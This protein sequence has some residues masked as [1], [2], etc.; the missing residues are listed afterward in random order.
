MSLPFAQRRYR[1]LHFLLDPP[2][3]ER[4]DGSKDEKG[5]GVGAADADFE[6][7]CFG[8]G[9]GRGNESDG[10]G[11]VLETPGNRDGGPEVLDEAFVGV[12]GGSEDG[13]DVWK[14]VKEAGEEVT[15][16]V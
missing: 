9:G 5:I 2:P 13:H 7:C 14:A 15:A 6:A 1:N 10:C 16:E 4:Q 3:P 8:A 11:A 12:D